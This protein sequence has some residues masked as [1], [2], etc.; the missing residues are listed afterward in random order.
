MELPR[1]RDPD[2][3]VP[4][5]DVSSSLQDALT[6][7]SKHK[8][9]TRHFICLSTP[10]SS[11]WS[12]FERYAT[13][14][15]KQLCMLTHDL[16]LE[17]RDNCDFVHRNLLICH[18]DYFVRS[19]ICDPFL[20]GSLVANPRDERGHHRRRMQEHQLNAV[21]ESAV[22]YAEAWKKCKPELTNGL[23]KIPKTDLHL[24]WYEKLL[25]EAV[26]ISRVCL[27]C[28][29]D[30]ELP[31]SSS[32]IVGMKMKFSVFTYLRCCSRQCVDALSIGAACVTF[33]LLLISLLASFHQ[34]PL[35]VAATVCGGVSTAASVARI[36][37][38]GDRQPEA[39]VED[40]GTVKLCQ[41]IPVYPQSVLP[42]PPTFLPSPG[43]LLP[44]GTA[45]ETS[46]LFFHMS[47]EAL[48]HL[49][50][51][52]F[53]SSLPHAVVHWSPGTQAVTGIKP[54]EVLGKPIGYVIGSDVDIGEMVRAG[55]KP[56]GA[57]KTIR[58]CFEQGRLPVIIDASWCPARHWSH[59]RCSIVVMVGSLR[60]GGDLAQQ[61]AVELFRH[62]ALGSVGPLSDATLRRCI[63][64]L[65]TQLRCAAQIRCAPFLLRDLPNKLLPA[66]TDV[67]KCSKPIF[68]CDERL[69]KVL[70]SLAKAS[71]AKM[72]HAST[73]PDSTALLFCFS[74]LTRR[75]TPA[76]LEGC[77]PFVS[78]VGILVPDD[79][80]AS[81]LFGVS[82]FPGADTHS[83][84]LDQ[85]DAN[86]L[87][88]LVVVPDTLQRCD[89]LRH[90]EGRG[91]RCICVGDSAA[92][93]VQIDRRRN[94]IGAV[95]A[96]SCH[97]PLLRPRCQ[98]LQVLLV[99]VMD[100]PAPSSGSLQTGA[101]YTPVDA[102][103][104]TRLVEWAAGRRQHSN[105]LT[106][107]VIEKQLGEGGQ[108]TVFLMR[109]RLTRGGMAA[110]R[111]NKDCAPAFHWE[112]SLLQQL[113]HDNI[114]G[115]IDVDLAQQ[116]P[117]LYLELGELDLKKLLL[118][119]SPSV[120]SISQTSLIATQLAA[121]INYL[122]SNFVAHQDIK[123]ENVILVDG[124]AKVSDFASAVKV[125]DGYQP[126]LTLTTL[127]H[128]AP[129]R[130]GVTAD[131]GTAFTADVWSLGTVVLS[132]LGLM[133]Q[134]L[135]CPDLTASQAKH[136]FLEMIKGDS[137][138]FIEAAVFRAK[139]SSLE[140]DSLLESFVDFIAKTMNFNPSRRMTAAQLH[141]HPFCV[142]MGK[143]AENQH[144]DDPLGIVVTK[145]LG[146]P[147]SFASSS[148]CGEVATRSN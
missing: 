70:T 134:V 24:E 121:A 56:S 145:S 67:S 99:E 91:H 123:P 119:R 92:A 33:L 11:D 81:F 52:A 82:T 60:K 94:G 36:F 42:E 113:K 18:L 14:T 45:E 7:A 21:I 72:V 130:F 23:I 8:W 118:Q 10:L 136:I 104:F 3:A 32:T 1:E 115:L 127:L 43:V 68:N 77:D 48:N 41:S 122:H 30:E 110:K 20:L 16:I 4:A 95:L 38:Q 78:A 57:L 105:E 138:P 79:D 142:K 89:I 90:A 128:S 139:N 87:V 148:S 140:S 35:L 143:P 88:F 126:P 102:A 53:S 117:C 12:A 5:P 73:S 83:M 58:L 114:I 65:D 69:G 112:L 98:D 103:S 106:N 141:L 62:V 47:L 74:D 19:F 31:G 55:E 40:S 147:L 133:P 15:L 120:L 71:G 49:V 108:S 34:F 59:A 109:N 135:L 54:S 116:T 132:A 101:L 9:R 26:T 6:E 39:G 51:I 28:S 131:R 2:A 144:D 46:Q 17:L 111:Y 63:L 125:Q 50:I 25:T 64:A 86:L 61:C 129:E 13:D 76:D 75:M 44:Y 146:G 84:A 37:F 80:S 22:R 96:S 100:R 137:N 29:C 97:M 107:F 85:L 27:W 124:V 66:F 93:F